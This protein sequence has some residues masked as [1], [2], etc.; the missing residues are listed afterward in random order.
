M[1]LGCQFVLT[2]NNPDAPTLE[3]WAPSN[4]FVVYIYLP[5]FVS[6]KLGQT[7]LEKIT[8]LF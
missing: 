1:H 3:F 2:V 6:E 4:D 5:F 7:H 8:E